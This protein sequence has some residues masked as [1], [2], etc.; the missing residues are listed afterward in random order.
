MENATPTPTPLPSTAAQAVAA[1]AD[2]HAGD[3]L[4]TWAEEF[5]CRV[6]TITVTEHGCAVRGPLPPLSA[7]AAAQLRLADDTNRMLAAIAHGP[8]IANRPPSV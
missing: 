3:P 5:G 2:A 6:R 1:Y 8:A 7:G 4:T